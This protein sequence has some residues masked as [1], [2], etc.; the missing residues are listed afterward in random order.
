[1]VRSSLGLSDVGADPTKW[2]Q[3]I[4]AQHINADKLECLHN[5]PSRGIVG[6]AYENRFDSIHRQ[7]S[8]MMY[9]NAQNRDICI[10][11]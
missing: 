6:I 11:R 10:V 3:L 2:R 7:E 4:D 8:E 1:V 9:D 5:W